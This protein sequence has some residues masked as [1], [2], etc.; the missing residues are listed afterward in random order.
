[1]AESKYPLYFEGMGQGHLDLR[2]HSL[3]NSFLL[4]D[5]K[6]LW[7]FGICLRINPERFDKVWKPLLELIMDTLQQCHDFQTATT[8]A[9]LPN[10]NKI[11]LLQ[12]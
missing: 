3:E 10:I 1:M 9:L 7:P 5:P 12:T 2:Q 4:L 11:W 6:L 8:V